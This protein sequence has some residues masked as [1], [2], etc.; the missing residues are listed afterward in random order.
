MGW[1]LKTSDFTVCFCSRVLVKFDTSMNGIK[2]PT[3]TLKLAKPGFL[4]TDPNR[5]CRAAHTAP[6]VVPAA[7]PYV[8]ERLRQSSRFSLLASSSAAVAS[9]FSNQRLVAS[10]DTIAPKVRPEKVKLRTLFAEKVTL[11]EQQEVP[12]I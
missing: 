3:K 1:I 11:G 2:K 6:T 7:K 5:I 10:S 9:R 8:A 4:R 12:R